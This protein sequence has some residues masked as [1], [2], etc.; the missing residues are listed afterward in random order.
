MKSIIELELEVQLLNLKLDKMT[1]TVKQLGTKLQ[2]ANIS[3]NDA[4]HEL[5]WY[6]EK[7]NTLNDAVCRVVLCKDE[8]HARALS[9]NNAGAF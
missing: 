7:Y 2:D 6:K 1:S 3:A 8:A 9:I 4:K 5:S